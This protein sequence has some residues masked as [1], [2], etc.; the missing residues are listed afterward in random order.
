MQPTSVLRT[1]CS[2]RSWPPSWNCSLLVLPFCSGGGDK[3]Q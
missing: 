1:S 3:I 2:V